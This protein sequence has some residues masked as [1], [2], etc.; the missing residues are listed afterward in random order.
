[1]R[2]CG[3]CAQGPTRVAYWLTVLA[4][5][6]T[7]TGVALVP[8]SLRDSRLAGLCFVGLENAGILSETYCVWK[9]DR[10]A[11][12]SLQNAIALIKAHRKSASRA[13]EKL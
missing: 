7:G 1:M 13:V 3:F 6:A 4:L 9:R 10:H 8:R 12:P 11:D 5:V 2:C